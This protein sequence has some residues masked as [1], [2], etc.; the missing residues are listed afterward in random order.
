MAY[1]DYSMGG[2]IPEETEEQR[3]RRLLAE[4]AQYQTQDQ[5]SGISQQP[6]GES[7]FAGAASR[8]LQNRMGAAEQ[9]VADAGQMFTD[10]Q[11][12]FDQ[13]MG[14]AQQPDAAN[15]EVQSQTVKTYGDGSQEQIVKTQTPAPEPVPVAPTAMAPQ[16][17]MAPAPAQMAQAAPQAQAQQAPL[18]AAP[19]SPEQLAQQQAA[20]AAVQQ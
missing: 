15:T 12:A 8:Y 10:P 4:Q 20:V 14:M 6:T 11:A 16:P 2:Y 3:R 17:A 1:D 7:G 13:R 18:S 5:E 19:V 9:R